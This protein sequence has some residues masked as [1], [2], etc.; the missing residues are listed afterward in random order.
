MT[1][2]T[3]FKIIESRLYLTLICILAAYFIN[4]FVILRLGFSIHK[5]KFKP[6][7]YIL[8]LVM[9]VYCL[10]GK[11]I[12][13]I[14]LFAPVGLGLAI[15][16]FM[17]YCQ[18][19]FFKS[20]FTSAFLYLISGIGY[21][22]VL[23]PLQIYNK[24]FAAFLIS[25]PSGMSL[26]TLAETFIPFILLLIKERTAISDTINRIRS[27]KI[28]AVYAVLSTTVYSGLFHAVYIVTYLYNDYPKEYLEQFLIFEGICIFIFFVAVCMLRRSD[29][30]KDELRNENAEL[31]KELDEIKKIV[32]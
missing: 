13:W 14:Q 3:L 10:T 17:K 6:F 20:V 18:I 21:M 11:T 9:V 23:Q 26:G 29:K 25:E 8:V 22:I 27:I 30:E 5:V 7:H 24:P 4:W 15:L 19:G 2:D 32:N 31:R 12:L 28:N 1:R 16:I